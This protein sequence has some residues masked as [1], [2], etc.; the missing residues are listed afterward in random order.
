MSSEKSVGREPRGIVRGQSPLNML[1]TEKGL[2]DTWET[3]FCVEM[4]GLEPPSKQRTRVL[5]TRLFFL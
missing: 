2:S 1:H 4:G 3:L 5:S